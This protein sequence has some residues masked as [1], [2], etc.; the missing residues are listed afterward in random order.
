MRDARRFERDLHRLAVDF[1]G[2]GERG[3][4]RQLR[5]DDQIAAVEL[6]DEADR[7]LAEFI[8]AEADDGGVD[9]QH[10]HRHAHHLGRKPTVAVRQGIEIM[11]EQVEKAVDRL[12]PP[13]FRFV[14]GMRLEQQR[15]QRRRQRQRD[16]QRNDGGAR[17]GECELPVELP[18]Y[19]G[20]EGGRY[21]HR[22]QHQ[23]DRDQRRAHFVH[24][25]DRG[26]VWRESRLNV[27]L[28]V[29]DDDDG[30]VDH[31][32]DGQHQAEQRQIV[33]R[34]A[35]HRHH[36]K[37][38]D[39]RHR[40]SDNRDDGGAPCLQKQDHHQHDQDDGL[41]NSRLYRLN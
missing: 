41:A 36:E 8:E 38:A 4:R 16:Y 3:G 2:A 22:R 23:R 29:F 15:A 13:A 30:V 27:A 9:H 12:A 19:A 21:E 40:D 5:D 32:A 6:R 34:E 24:A 20:N 11:V 31:N 10:Q 17:D 14:F 37:R 35:E 39:Q 28:D 18:R 26:V 7:R 1:V 33:E 25:F